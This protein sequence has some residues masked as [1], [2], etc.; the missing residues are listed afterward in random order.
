MGAKTQ[1]DYINEVEYN[2]R[3]TAKNFLRSTETTGVGVLSAGNTTFPVRSSARY[4]A[5]TKVFLVYN[6]TAKY[7]S[8]VEVTSLH[9]K[10]AGDWV[11]AFPAGSTIKQCDSLQYIEEAMSIFSKYKPRELSASI[12]G[13][14][15][16]KY[17]VPETWVQDFSTIQNVEYPIDEVPPSFV[18]KNQYRIGIADDGDPQIIFADNLSASQTLKVIFTANHTNIDGATV[19]DVKTNTIPDINFHCVVNLSCYCY[20]L[21]QASMAGST[22]NPQLNAEIVNY[23][24]R[25]D[26]YRRLAKEFLGKAASWLG[27]D[28]EEINTGKIK[29]KASSINQS[30]PTINADGGSLLF[31]NTD[32]G[33][34]YN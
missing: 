16:N 5:D 30:I 22:E 33:I 9:I 32:S 29:Q 28:I 19:T 24:N 34:I 10:V 3:D 27:I 14:G 6:N 17:D 26:A 25:V 15:T 2:V 7:V 12:V 8:V 1:I 23:Q 11:S 21:A 18:N 20:L 13:D 4:N 31:K